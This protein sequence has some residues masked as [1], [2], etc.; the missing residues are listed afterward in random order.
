[1]IFNRRVITKFLDLVDL[2][3]HN[4]NY[5]EIEA[6][7]TDHEE[8][9]TVAKDDIDNHKA[10]TTAHAAEHITYAGPVAGASD[11][12]GAVDSVQQQLN[13]AVMEGDSGPAAAQAAI[14]ATGHDYGNLKV[15]LDTEHTA[16]SA[17]LAEIAKNTTVINVAKFGAVGD[18]DPDTGTGT[19]DTIAIQNAADALYASGGGVLYYPEEAYKTTAPILM[20]LPATDGGYDFPPIVFLGKGN[21]G[22]AII[23]VGTAQ[24]YGLDA[25]VILIKGSTMNL[26]DAFSAAGFKN[27]RITNTSTGN[28]TYAVYGDNGS[29][30]IAEYCSFVTSK[31]L[32]TVST[33]DRYAFYIRSMWACSLRDCTFSGDY[34]FYIASNSTSTLL[35]NCFAST[36]KTAYHIVG[37]YSTIINTYGDFCNGTMYHFSF[38]SVHCTAIG[39]ESPNCDTMIRLSNS[40]VTIDNAYFFQ[41]NLDAG[42]VINANGSTLRIRQLNMIMGATLAGYLWTAGTNSN[43]IV[44]ALLMNGPTKFKYSE[45]STMSSDNISV[46]VSPLEAPITKGTTGLLP[47]RSTGY[48]DWYL[49]TPAIPINNIIMGL[50][51]PTTAADG[52]DVQWDGGAKVNN[53]Y[54][55]SDFAN[56]LVL[57]WARIA[58]TSGT[59]RDGTVVYAP[60]AI[61]CTTANRPTNPYTGMIIHDQTLDKLC[62]WNGTNWRTFNTTGINA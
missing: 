55:N 11:I 6:D 31:D 51:G 16:V 52:S 22:S 41:S 23:K 9:I 25:T 28:T 1:M 15:R 43:I 12:K 59:L 4:D 54:L 38:C 48:W 58:Q 24:S 34:G 40:Q 50:K 45:I 49:N 7:L 35:E 13:T 33:H 5:A 29:R 62:W 60:L 42:T 17:Q 20:K 56:R 26:A 14:D 19:D 32:P 21:R 2:Q 53:F 37:V 18:Y 27:I 10:S 61:S 57:G 3:R 36:D 47:F 39:G 46:F 30:V 44:E 8:R